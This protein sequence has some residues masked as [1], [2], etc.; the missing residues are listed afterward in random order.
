MQPVV[1]ESR[2]GND[3]VLN[4]NVPV[5]P[6][7]ANQAVRVTIEAKPPSTSEEERRRILLSLAGSI[8]DPAFRRYEQGEY[9]IRDELE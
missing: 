9:E 4:L 8:T 5:G 6:E 2:V 7:A 1:I 3:G